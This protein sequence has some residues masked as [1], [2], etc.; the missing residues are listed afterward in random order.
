[1]KKEGK[2]K[3]RESRIVLY[4]VLNFEGKKGEK[5]LLHPSGMRLQRYLQII[6]QED[7]TSQRK[8]NPQS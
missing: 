6:H 3:K 1:M 7:P 8:L 4:I 5:G 2:K